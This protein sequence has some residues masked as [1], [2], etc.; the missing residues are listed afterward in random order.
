M[1]CGGKLVV[2][3]S[4]L[5]QIFN[6]Q[7][8]QLAQ[9]LVGST[10]V[11]RECLYVVIIGRLAIYQLLYVGEQ[12]FLLVL[13]V[14]TYFVGILVVKL[15]YQSAQRVVLVQTLAQLSANVRQL[16]L[17]KIGVAGLQIVQQG[18]HADLFVVVKLA[19]TVHGV[20]HHCQECVGVHIIVLA[21]FAYR[22]ISKTKVYAKA[23]KGLQQIVVIA[24]Q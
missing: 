13:H 2:V 1:Q 17:Q 16:K 12:G 22:F 4:V 15:Q 6:N 8:F 18:G 11:L 24:D 10:V 3:Q 9:F 20:V 19:I 23:S 14:A 5:W 7:Q 21:G